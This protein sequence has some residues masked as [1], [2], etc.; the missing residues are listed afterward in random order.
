MCAFSLPVVTLGLL[1]LHEISSFVA[2][3][4]LCNKPITNVCARESATTCVVVCRPV[5]ALLNA[6][7]VHGIVMRNINLLKGIIVWFLHNVNVSKK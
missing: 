6:I 4:L 5:L 7:R 3:W 2:D 1:L